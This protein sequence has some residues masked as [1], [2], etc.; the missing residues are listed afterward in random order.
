M[1]VCEIVDD[2]T[3]FATVRETLYEPCTEYACAGF[4]EEDVAPSPKLHCHEVGEPVERSVNVT[5]SRTAGDDGV[6]PNAAETGGMAGVAVT[7]VTR[8]ELVDVKP[9]AVDTLSDTEYVP[10]NE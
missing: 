4:C 10:A 7:T 9:P 3:A 8:C 2:E 6:E 1:I 5:L